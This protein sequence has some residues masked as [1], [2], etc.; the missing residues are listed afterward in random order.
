MSLRNNAITLLMLLAA[1]AAC[2]Q[3]MDP[4]AALAMPF[5]ELAQAQGVDAQALAAEVGLPE[6]ADLSEQTGPLLKANEL[7]LQDLQSAMQALRNA[8]TG[9]PE[10]DPPLEGHSA[11]EAEAA[12]KDW[13]KIR[14][15]FIL[16]VACFVAAL[17]MLMLTK[18]RPLV[19]VL[20]LLAAAAI[21]GVWLGVEPNAPG[22]IKDGI[23]LYATSGEIFLPRL[24][25]FA[26]FL[27]MSIIGGK[28]FCGWCCQFGTLQDAIWHLPTKKWKP[29]FALSNTFRVGALLL[30]SIAAFGYGADI[31]EP[32]DP[33]RIFRLGALWA[34]ITAVAVLIASV[35]VYRPWCSFF[36][37]FGLVSWVAE[38]IAITKPRVNLK[39]CIDCLR[40]ERACPN[41]SIQGLRRGRK[42]PQDC[43]ACGTCIRVCPVNAIRWHITPPPNDPEPVAHDESEDDAA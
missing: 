32:I 21:F 2:A 42:A 12:S 39:T 7:S 18:V 10:G 29:P 33:F 40:C 19:R 27:L 1:G 31:L 20:M 6:G 24:M 25:A 34:V 35:W 37:P 5:A 30:I 26:G 41:F 11:V 28:L 17:L 3:Q 13:G 8:Q 15:K 36:C 14:L 22:T 23:M 38:R 4:N 9:V 16:W 43:F